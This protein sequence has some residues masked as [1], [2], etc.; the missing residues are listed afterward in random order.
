MDKRCVCKL[1]G[2]M[3][4]RQIPWSR[5]SLFILRCQKAYSHTDGLIIKCMH[6]ALSS[7]WLSNGHPSQ[8]SLLMLLLLDKLRPYF[9]SHASIDPAASRGRLHELLQSQQS[10]SSGVQQFRVLTL[11]SSANLSNCSCLYSRKRIEQTSPQYW[12]AL[13]SRTTHQLTTS[14]HRRLTHSRRRNSGNLQLLRHPPQ[15]LKV[16]SSILQIL[17]RLEALRKLDRRHVDQD[18]VRSFRF[19]V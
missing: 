15:Q 10:L 9:S 16:G 1:T 3:L 12:R 2:K 4:C 19:S 13:H 6:S 11:S 17:R 14:L 7:I 8:L 18:K 5:S